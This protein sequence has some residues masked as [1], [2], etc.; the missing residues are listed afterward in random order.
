MNVMLLFFIEGLHI[1]TPST[2][3]INQCWFSYNDVTG[4]NI[5][6]WLGFAAAKKC[7]CSTIDDCGMSILRKS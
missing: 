6:V 3:G 2:N 7:D 4:Y 5:T 1:T